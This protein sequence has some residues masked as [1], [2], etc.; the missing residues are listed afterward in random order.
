M[1]ERD[2]YEVLG[3]PETASEADIKRA[4]RK[5]VMQWHPDRHQGDAD[6]AQVAANKIQEINIA[7][8]SVLREQHK[9]SLPG[10][11]AS[12][13]EQWRSIAGLARAG[14]VPEMLDALADLSRQL[15][16]QVG[17]IRETAMRMTDTM[18]DTATR[19]KQ[20]LADCSAVWAAVVGKK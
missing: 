10:W 14:Q 16:D 2:P 13:L 9:G 18:I 15:R 6:A 4:Y 7:F 12:I 20:V 11:A 19:G 5:L 1:N 8:E 3:V 17:E